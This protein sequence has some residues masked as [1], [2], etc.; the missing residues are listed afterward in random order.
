MSVK[1]PWE[2]ERTRFTKEELVECCDRWKLYRGREKGA[3]EQDVYV[4]RVFDISSGERF[5][6]E[7]M[8]RV[9][10]IKIT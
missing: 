3:S 6:E 9:L 10:Q 4:D 1:N 2:H 7:T 5:L 8:A